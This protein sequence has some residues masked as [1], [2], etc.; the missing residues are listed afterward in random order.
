MKGKRSVVHCVV[1]LAA[2]LA[3][4]SALPAV[5]GEPCCQIA[6]INARTGVVTAKVN[7]T[8]QTFQFTLNNRTQLGQLKAGQGVYANF[9]AN[10]VSLDGSSVAGV[11]INTRGVDGMRPVAAIPPQDVRDRLRRMTIAPNPADQSGK[12]ALLNLSLAA[13][14]DGSRLPNSICASLN[15]EA[16]DLVDANHNGNYTGRLSLAQRFAYANAIT[17]DANGQQLTAHSGG[18]AGAGA[19]GFGGECHMVP[20]PPD[21]KSPTGAR[22]VVCI[23]CSVTFGRPTTQTEGGSKH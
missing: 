1:S 3:V 17:F 10:Q 8:G 18:I 7:G 15:G 6:A 16:V 14:L 9:K 2:L 12:S 13:P 5:A 20:C 19:P 21:C 23:S 22:C 4:F 11:I